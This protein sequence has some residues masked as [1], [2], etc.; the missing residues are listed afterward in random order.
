V[1]TLQEV[2]NQDFFLS[3][4]MISFFYHFQ[5]YFSYIVVVSLNGG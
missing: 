2:G 3:L 5:Q 1:K 4:V